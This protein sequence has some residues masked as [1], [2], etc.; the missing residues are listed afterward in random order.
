MTTLKVN[1][2]RC[3]H[4]VQSV[5]KALNDLDGIT[6]VSVDLEKKEVTFEETVPIDLEVVKQT[7]RD[8][9]FDVA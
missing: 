4:C 7:I 9:G 6:H 2:M 1:G 5:T 3:Q 8:T